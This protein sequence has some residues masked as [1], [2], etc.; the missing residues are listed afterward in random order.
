MNYPSFPLTISQKNIFSQEIVFPNTPINNICTTLNITGR[1]DFGL[2]ET[3]LNTILRQDE[4]LRIRFTADDEHQQY[5]S[6]FRYQ[7]L[8]IFDFTQTSQEGIDQWTQ[9]I[10]KEIMPLYDSPLYQFCLFKTEERHGG[11]LL[12]THHLISDGYTQVLLCNRIAELYLKLINDK[13]PDELI[14]FPYLNH[15]TNEQ[16]YLN[17]ANYFKDQQYWM[18]QTALMTEAVSMKEFRSAALTY[19]GHRLTFVLSEKQNHL[20]YQYCLQKRISPFSLF[21]MALAIWLKRARNIDTFTLGVPIVNRNDYK[22]KNTSGMFVSTLPFIGTVDANWNINDFNEQL[23]EHWL[24]MLKHQRFPFEEINKLIRKQNPEMTELFHL[25]LSYQNSLAYQTD[26]TQVYFDGRWNYS[27][28]Q[29]Q[30]LCIHIS[31]RMDLQQYTIDYDYLVQVFSQKEICSIHQMLMIILEDALQNPA[32]PIWALKFLSNETE[33]NVLYHFSTNPQRYLTLR[34]VAQTLTQIAERNPNKIAIIYQGNRLSYYDLTN[35]AYHF[36]QELKTCNT[37]VVALSMPRTPALLISM[38]ACAF[39]GK[40]WVIIDPKLPAQRCKAIINDAQAELIV[41]DQPFDNEL[42]TIR[43]RPAADTV[44]IP[45]TGPDDLDRLAYLVYTSGTSGMPKGV[46]ILER[47]LVNFAK[48][49][50]ELYGHGAVLSICNVGFD[51]FVLESMVSLL[52]EQTIV[53]AE[54]DKLN[55]PNYLVSLIH[56]H[57]IGLMAMTP[58]R[59]AAYLQH[60]TFLKTLSRIETIICGGE[61]FPSELLAKIRQ[62]SNARIINQYGPSEATIGVSYQELNKARL[63][64]VGKPMSGCRL[65]VLDEHLLPLP[66]LS[67]GEVYIGGSCLSDGYQ[68]NP[69][70][71]QAA[72]LPNPYEPQEKLYRSKDLGYWNHDGELVIVG[73]KDDQIKL[74][75]YRIELQEIAGKLLSYPAVSDAAV[76]TMMISGKTLLVAYYVGDLQLDEQQLRTYLYSYLPYYMIPQHLIAVDQIPLTANGKVDYGALPKIETQNTASVPQNDLEQELLALVRRHLKTDDF[77]TDSD[78]FLSGGDSLSAIELLT[79][80]EEK[81]HVQ[82]SIMELYSLRTVKALALKLPEH[83]TTKLSDGI[84]F[85]LDADRYPLTPIQRN[86]YVMQAIQQDTAYNM[87]GLLRFKGRIDLDRMENALTKL[88][89]SNPILRSCFLTSNNDVTAQIVSCQIIIEHPAAA[90]LEQAIQLFIRPFDLRQAPLIRVAYFADGPDDILLLDMHHIIMDGV[91]TPLLLKKLKAAYEQPLTVSRELGYQDYAWWLAQNDQHLLARQRQYWQS[92]L[93]E[94]PKP[95]IFDRNPYQDEILTGAERWI[96]RFDPALSRTISETALALKL[97]PYML[98]VTGFGLLLSRLTKQTKISI[99]TVS[100]GRHHPATQSMIGVFINTL[101]LIMDFSATT[102]VH[103]LLTLIGQ[104]TIELLDNSDISQE[105]LIKDLHLPHDISGH[106]FYNVLFSMRPFVNEPIEFDHVAAQLTSLANPALKMDLAVDAFTEDDHFSFQYEFDQRLLSVETIRYCHDCYQT[107]LQNICENPE[108]DLQTIPTVPAALHIRLIEQPLALRTPYHAQFLDRTIDQQAWL[109]PHKPA[110]I[111]HHETMTFETLI[112]KADALAALLMENGIRRNDAVAVAVN[113]GFELVISLLAVMKAGGTYV[114]LDL[115]FPLTRLTYMLEISAAKVIITT[116]DTADKLSGTSV[117]LLDCTQ[118]PA[119]KAQPVKDRQLDDNMYILFTSGS[120][121]NPKGVILPHHALANLCDAMQ[122]VY[123]DLTHPVLCSTNPVFDVFISES[124]LA[125]AHGQTIVMCDEQEMLMPWE[126]AR[127]INEYQVDLVQFTPSRCAF[128]LNNNDFFQALAHVHSMILVGE[129]LTMNLMRK[130]QHTG[131]INIF[132]FYGPTEAAVYV[133]YI[134]L[135]NAEAVTIGKPLANCRIYVLDEHKRRLPPLVSGQLYLAGT[136]LA[137][138]YSQQPE[139]TAE[140]FCDDPFFSGEKMYRSGDLGYLDLEG[141]LVYLSRLDSQIKL[142]GHRIEVQEINESLL[143]AKLVREAVTIPVKL[144]G[145]I[146]HLHTFAV[147]DQPAE[148]LKTYLKNQLPA[149]MVPSQVTIVEHIPLNASGKADYK[150]LL[151]GVKT[152][153]S[154][155]ISSVSPVS[156]PGGIIRRIWQDALKCDSINDQLSFFDQGGTSLLALVILSS[157]YNEG[158]SLTMKDFYD[159]P[160]LQEQLQLLA[161]AP[162]SGTKTPA[163]TYRPKVPNSPLNRTGK[164]AVL[165]TGASGYLGA[166]LLYYLCT[167]PACIIYCLVR[168]KERLKTNLLYYF[169]ADWYDRHQHQLIAIN[170]DITKDHLGLMPVMYHHL[171]ANIGQ[172]IHSAAN[173][174]HY[175]SDESITVTNLDGT[176][177]LLQLAQSCQAF[178]HYVSTTGI[179][180]DTIINPQPAYTAFDETSFDVGQNWMDNSYTRS[181]FLAEEAVYQAIDQGLGAHVYRV[182]HLIGRTADGQFQINPDKNEIYRIMQG[183]KELQGIPDIMARSQLELTPVDACAEALIKLLRSEMTTYHLYNPQLIDIKTCL[184]D[185]PVID[186]IEMSRRI[187]ELDLSLN[188]HL[189]DI[190]AACN[191]LKKIEKELLIN[192]DLTVACLQET[193]FSWPELNTDRL[194]G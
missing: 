154:G 3:V 116:A 76:T 149:Y 106:T 172:I 17:S 161:A 136:C 130:I 4:S 148:Q 135:K 164:P 47:S 192:C 30:H 114:P 6:P 179:L 37:A 141:N 84:G 2:L 98:L 95:L 82:L 185:L 10:S 125:L 110:I 74:H 177:N 50:A 126:M 173:V 78:Y 86:L 102:S 72:F 189:P 8:A 20:I 73:R 175:S 54:D 68:N 28:Y 16:K 24:E 87:P 77:Y 138:G 112:A 69:Q 124:L 183:L 103:S 92:Q 145:E 118:Q 143:R 9:I 193:D 163:I 152:S 88:L 128:C 13:Q 75:G 19:V 169:T 52:N 5:V 194:L 168:D 105:D 26:S 119:G 44:M 36:A 53:L 131:P 122:F 134:N 55:N 115:D 90:T 99:G 146:Q 100:A 35:Q 174:N 190:V 32:K 133:S 176:H 147:S 97:T 27:G 33:N 59:L 71:T 70:E 165:L 184:P 21:Y 127:L 188:P 15:L 187:A 178:F 157:Y 11:I 61:V 79:E 151:S 81:Y 186:Q 91:S 113:R 41:T 111:F 109:N 89:A 117:M 120:T 31:N 150:Q 66:P 22:E 137:K 156:D 142:N 62:F 108:A 56:N 63:I 67:V 12:K 101:P 121:G 132:N 153:E 159:H 58:S 182:G 166:Y 34:S 25:V 144:N 64:S 38:L 94:L 191:R 42:K 139:L 140:A 40:A 39:A 181:K 83:E 65:Y 45:E 160:T 93:S 123:A 14:T 104:R 51:A 155:I 96:G 167:D 171:Q 180:G 162:E 60:A 48:A 80:I 49:S 85:A 23:M 29:G 1:I 18:K 170:G 7:Q 57:A 107:I 43:F 158:W 129:A 46:R